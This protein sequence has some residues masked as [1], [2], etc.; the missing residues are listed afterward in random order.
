MKNRFCFMSIVLVVFSAFTLC[1][2]ALSS[3]HGPEEM[4]RSTVCLKEYPTNPALFKDW[5]QPHVPKIIAK[6]GMEEWKAVLLTNELH[7]HLGMWSIVGAKMGV[8][9]REILNVP[10]DELDVVSWAGTRPPYSCLNDG[11]Q[12]STGA[13][14]G[15]G[16]ITN[17]HLDLP[18]VDFIFK[19]E[20]TKATLRV[21]PEIIQEIARIIKQYSDKYKF[22]SPE[23]F[24]QLDKISVEYWLNWDRAKIFYEKTE[25]IR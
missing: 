15:R 8:R 12:V 2:F 10:F 11:I 3:A 1:L 24:D 19:E 7:R 14:L 5:L 18:I 25:K 20:G 13:S 17:A 21:K 4:V 6:H 16:T 23:Y 22:Q 9:A